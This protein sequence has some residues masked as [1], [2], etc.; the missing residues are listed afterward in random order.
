MTFVESYRSSFKDCFKG[1]GCCFLLTRAQCQVRVF[2]TEVCPN[3]LTCCWQFVWCPCGLVMIYRANSHRKSSRLRVIRADRALPLAVFMERVRHFIKS[4]LT[5]I[6]LAECECDAV[7]CQSPYPAAPGKR[8][9]LKLMARFDMGFATEF[10]EKSDIRIVNAFQFCLNRLAWQRLP[11]WVCGAFQIFRVLAH[12]SVVGIRQAGFVSL[13]LPLMKIL[14]HLPHIVKQ[15]ANAYRIRLIVPTDIYRFSW[16]FT[17][18]A[19]DPCIEW[20][21]RHVTLRVTLNACLPT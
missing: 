21:G 11:M 10:L 16:T 2:H 5:L 1:C 4:P 6:P 13:V 15:V 14:M 8:D 12:C 18:H 9:R 19:F 20:V 17:S 7:V 3:A